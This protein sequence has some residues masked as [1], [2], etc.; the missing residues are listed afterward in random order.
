MGFIER[1]YTNTMTL[2]D[3][4]GQTQFESVAS[5]LAGTA[6]VLSALVVVLVLINMALQVRPMEAGTS[7][8]LI[9]KLV[10]VALFMQSWAD[11]NGVFGAIE[12]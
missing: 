7:V 9:F 12:V 8:W 11:F 5:Q 3:S 4:L 1:T 6:Q 10:L 2:L